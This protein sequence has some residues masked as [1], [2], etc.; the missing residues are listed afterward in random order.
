MVRERAR[1]VASEQGGGNQP[2]ETK[3]DGEAAV[4]CRRRAGYLIKHIRETGMAGMMADKVVSL[5]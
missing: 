3:M 1:E 2:I 5:R 4:V